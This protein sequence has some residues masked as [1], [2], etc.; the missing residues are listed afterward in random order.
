[1]LMLAVGDLISKASLSVPAFPLYTLAQHMAQV[2]ADII[3]LQEIFRFKN[4]VQLPEGP[5]NTRRKLSH[6]KLRGKD[7]QVLLVIGNNV[8]V[9]LEVALG[10]FHDCLKTNGT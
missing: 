3:A 7:P 2:L 9:R 4:T 8:P 5:S 6:C 1:M 10:T